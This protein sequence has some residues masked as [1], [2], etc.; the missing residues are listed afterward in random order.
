MIQIIS[1]NF[2]GSVSQ[3]LFTRW[4]FSSKD[5]TWSFDFYLNTDLKMVLKCQGNFNFKTLLHFDFLQEGHLFSLPIRRYISKILTMN[6]EYLINKSYSI[7][8]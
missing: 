7:A 4:F 3:D 1:F 5:F 6:N 8:G 2:R